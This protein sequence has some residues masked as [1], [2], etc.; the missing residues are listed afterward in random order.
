[1]HTSRER[2]VLQRTAA[3]LRMDDGVS[4]RVTDDIQADRACA[5]E[6]LCNISAS[7]LRYV[8]ASIQWRH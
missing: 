3:T 2:F 5:N 7:V 6:L 1:M 4:I 8:S